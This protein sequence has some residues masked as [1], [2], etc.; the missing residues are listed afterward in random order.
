[1]NWVNDF[2]ST[3]GAISRCI[4]SSDTSALA[5]HVSPLHLTLVHR[6]SV[7]YLTTTSAARQSKWNQEDSE[8][9][10]KRRL[11]KIEPK[12]GIMYKC[13]ICGSRNAQS[14]SKKSYEEGVV[15][16]KCSN[17]KNNHLI[18]DNLGWFK[19]VKGRNIE[20]ILASK[21]EEVMKACDMDLPQDMIE[22]YNLHSQSDQV[23][24]SSSSEVDELTQEATCVVLRSVQDERGKKGT[25]VQKVQNTKNLKRKEE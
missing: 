3:S 10:K 8:T 18:A 12:M 13:K 1:M 19:E 21:G 15:I 14:F 24:S 23:S 11:M 2:R 20:E 4:L 16:V 5:Q 22:K 17:C 25:L 7:R 9:S 6:S